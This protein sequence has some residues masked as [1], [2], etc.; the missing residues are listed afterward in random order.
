MS[1]NVHSCPFAAPTMSASMS[2]L[3]EI[4]G[5]VTLTVSFVDPDPSADKP[6]ASPLLGAPQ[7]QPHARFV[8]ITRLGL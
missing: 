6:L 1:L 4:T 7:R 3:G 5:R 8:Y 2:A